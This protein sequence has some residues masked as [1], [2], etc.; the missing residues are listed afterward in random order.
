MGKI[1]ANL[2]SACVTSFVSLLTQ[3]KEP[4]ENIAEKDLTLVTIECIFQEKTS[5]SDKGKKKQA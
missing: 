2:A 4:E 5:A 1:V 3:R